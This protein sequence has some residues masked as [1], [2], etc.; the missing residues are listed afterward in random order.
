MRRGPMFAL[1]LAAV[2]SACSG[3]KPGARD[4]GAGHDGAARD[5]AADAVDGLGDDVPVGGDGPSDASDT[6][7]AEPAG[8]VLQFNNRATRD[9]VYVDPAL[10][11]AAL[12][13][14]RLDPAFANAS[15]AGPLAARP[16]TLDGVGGGRD[17][18]IVATTS[19]RVDAFDADTGQEAWIRDLGPPA[20]RRTGP[21][22]PG[23]LGIEGTP[24]IDA[25]RR[26]LYVDVPTSRDNG[27]T[28]QHLVYALDADT[29]ATR[30]GW[31]VDVGALLAG[32][33]PAFDAA[34]LSQPA[35]LT[36]VGDTLVLGYGSFG[37]DGCGD[38]RGWVVALSTTDPTG[39]ATWAA[40]ARAG[41]EAAGGVSFDGTS[42]FFATARGAGGATW[43]D[44]QA[45][46][47]LPPSLAFGG[48][49]AD[50]F[51]EP[52]FAALD[53]A[54]ADLG[55]TAP[56][57]FELPGSTPSRLLFIIGG[58]GKAHLLDRE[59]LGGLAAPLADDPVAGSPV[60]TAPV[61]FS[62]PKGTFVTYRGTRRA[63]GTGTV[64]T[65]KL[66][67][68]TP[69]HFD[70]ASCQ[71]P[72]D[73]SA[74]AVSMTDTSGKDAFVWVA[75]G[76]GKL[77]A[78]DVVEGATVLAGTADALDDT[79]APTMAPIIRKGR[80]FVAGDNHLFAWKP[81]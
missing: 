62:T 53:A 25:A 66:A 15:Y 20:Q 59:S 30:A 14:L 52:G 55:A 41:V 43:L 73:G 42:L 1:A 74:P 47:A 71:L 24:V 38:Y 35:A 36:L 64:L 68:G 32:H 57:P 63:C 23:Q 31:P 50:F 2:A 26:A 8:G 9:G 4:G 21:C 67:P 17:L 33:T 75:G 56:I 54:G 61:L 78:L 34:A 49:P 65:R 19:D 10:T 7:D 80:I 40:R 69:P 13:T 77:Y 18:I 5:A 27:L 72:G 44:G 48:Q 58:E 79:V 60:T 81:N 16:V 28:N 22:A 70:V 76:D 12:P 37:G 6:P 3:A 45:V 29:G 46:F 39:V 11:R 51:A